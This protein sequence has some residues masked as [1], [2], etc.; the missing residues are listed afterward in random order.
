[1]R[2]I[3]GSARG[4]SICAPKGHDTRP[5]QDY[6]R[7]SLFNILQQAVPD[8]I[9]L[10]LFAG[11]GALAL[12]AISRGAEHAV[13][14]DSATDAMR[15][16]EQNVTAL[17]FSEQI[18]LQKC[19]WQLALKRLRGDRQFTLVFID[20]PYKMTDTAAQ[21]NLLMQYGLLK[22][23]ATLVIE[24]RKGVEPT[25]SECFSLRSIRSYGD[26]V[27]HIYTYQEGEI[28]DA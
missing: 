24:H 26:T 21:C 10:D 18:T 4:R 28:A 5:T 11:S 6:V 15:C 9:V 14:V 20:P 19:D 27:I 3:A 12:E 2:I 1:M 7:E 13:L 17:R 8:A 25:L 23:N 16:I 22:P